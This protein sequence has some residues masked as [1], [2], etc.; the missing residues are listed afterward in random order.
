MRNRRQ[1]EYRNLIGGEELHS[2]DEE[3]ISSG[4]RSFFRLSAF[5]WRSLRSSRPQTAWTPSTGR[6]SVR[7]SSGSNVSAGVGERWSAFLPH[8]EKV[9]GLNLA[10][11]R[12]SC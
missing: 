3:V 1:Q 7:L 10:A 11:G 6:G 4:Q 5:M 9:L 12:V 2:E 8:R